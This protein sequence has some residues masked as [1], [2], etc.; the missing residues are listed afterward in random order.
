MSP[1]AR[2]PS[3][4][5]LIHTHVYCLR[6]NVSSSKELH[7]IRHYFDSAS[8]RKGDGVRSIEALC[9]SARLNAVSSLCPPPPRSF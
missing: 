2:G 9:R 8:L 6:Q 3:A 1:S 5:M 4:R 7:G